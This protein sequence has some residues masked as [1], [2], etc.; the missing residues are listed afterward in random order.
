MG[1]SAAALMVMAV[2][3]LAQKDVSGDRFIAV[4]FV[5]KVEIWNGGGVDVFTLQVL[6]R[7]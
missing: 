6:E 7:L 3:I 2:K 1:I 5:L 4:W